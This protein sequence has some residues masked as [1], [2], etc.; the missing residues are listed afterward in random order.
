[1]KTLFMTLAAVVMFLLNM[2]LLGKVVS[3]IT[4][5]ICAISAIYAFGKI[6]E[7]LTKG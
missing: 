2:G 1:M 6:Y 5:I 3:I 7:K 4:V